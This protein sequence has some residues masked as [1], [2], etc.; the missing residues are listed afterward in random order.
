MT[1]LTTDHITENEQA[2]KEICNNIKNSL[3]GRM[4][5]EQLEKFEKDFYSIT[6]GYVFT[7]KEGM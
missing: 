7:R 3:K 2:K 1:T 6:K 5:E 4:T